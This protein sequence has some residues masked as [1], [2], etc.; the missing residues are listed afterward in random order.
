MGAVATGVPLY[1]PEALDILHES[2]PPDR[3]EPLLG[4]NLLNLS[5]AQRIDPNIKLADYVSEEVLPIA[6]SI[7]NTCQKDLKAKVIAESLTYNRVF[8]KSPA[9]YLTNAFSKMGYPR[10]DLPVPTFIGTGGMDKDTPPDMQKALI[11]QLCKAGSVIVSRFYPELDHRGVVPVSTSDTLPF[12]KAAFAGE[13]I[14]SNC[15]KLP[16]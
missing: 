1:S 12:V 9:E 4:Y 10:F 3:I 11:G 14:E 2:R 5:L 16:F 8:K 15:G 6:Q 13:E 7:Q